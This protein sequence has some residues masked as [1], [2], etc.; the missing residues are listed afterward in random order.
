MDSKEDTGEKKKNSTEK[1]MA[2]NITS[3]INPALP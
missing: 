3:L 2:S 1:K